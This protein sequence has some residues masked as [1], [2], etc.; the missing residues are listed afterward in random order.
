MWFVVLNGIAYV[1]YTIASGEWRLL[2]P[3]SWSAFGNAWHVVRYD[4]GL[5]K[6][7]PAQDKYNAAQQIT[8]TGIIL[9]GIGS[10]LTGLAIYKPIQL[11]WL[12]FLFGGYEFARLIHFA[13]TIGYL[14][15]FVVHIAQVVR[16]GWRNFQSMISGYEVEP[17]EASD[18]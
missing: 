11:S 10:F 6:I 15:F 9:M 5:D 18:E 12:T 16:A 2:V 17:V 8:Y 14:L 7:L 1:T 3:Q 13:L 4:L